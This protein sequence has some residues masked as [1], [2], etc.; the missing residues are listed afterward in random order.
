MFTG[1]GKIRRRHMQ[2][3][4]GHRVRKAFRVIHSD[5]SEYGT[6]GHDGSKYFIFF[7]INDY[8]KFVKSYAIKNKSDVLVYFWK[9]KNEVESLE[10]VTISQVGSDNGGE[11]GAE[12]ER[13]DF[14]KLCNTHRI[15]QT[16]GPPHTPELNG[17]AE[18]WNQTIKEKICCSLLEAG[19]PDSFRPFTLSYCT[20]THNQ[21]PTRTNSKYTAPVSLT[22]F[23]DCPLT[24]FHTFGCEAWFHVQNT[25]SKLKL[26]AKCGIF[27]AH[28]RNNLGA[29][30]YDLE[31]C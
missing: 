14:A 17:V 13:S 8:S 18:R 5:V 2:S 4:D 23:K 28:L 1:Q 26:R 19:L 6:P 3:R 16:M 11:Y 25:S 21:L 20:E 29:Y 31:K 7:F 27:L 9:Y 30:V 15:T 22:G 24:D 12:Y 10:G